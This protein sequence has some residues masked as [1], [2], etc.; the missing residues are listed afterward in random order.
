VLGKANQGEVLLQQTSWLMAEP[1][2]KTTSSSTSSFFEI[3]HCVLVKIKRKF[4]GSLHLPG[5]NWKTALLNFSHKFSEKYK[6]FHY[7]LLFYDEVDLSANDYSL[8]LIIHTSRSNKH[9]V[10]SW[11]CLLTS[12]LGN[13]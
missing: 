12:S 11:S 10:L 7:K 13:S 9:K 8:S 2:S 3:P 6:P 1:T 5:N 4:N